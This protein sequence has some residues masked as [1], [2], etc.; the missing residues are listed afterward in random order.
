MDFRKKTKKTKSSVAPEGNGF[1]NSSFEL[2]L[3]SD[4][5]VKNNK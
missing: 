2:N 1:V 3:D 4:Q 5:S